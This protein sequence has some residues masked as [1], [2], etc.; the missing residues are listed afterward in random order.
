MI[1]LKNK[2]KRVN[3]IIVNYNKSSKQEWH[4]MLIE[5]LG[6]VSPLYYKIKYYIPFSLLL[7][8]T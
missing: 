3:E 6:F 1:H 5:Q 2:L 4:K 8:V 7:F